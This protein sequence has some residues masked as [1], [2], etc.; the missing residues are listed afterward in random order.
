MTDVV[1]ADMLVNL[2][3]ICNDRPRVRKSGRRGVL[4]LV[5]GREWSSFETSVG[6]RI[7]GEGCRVE[8]LSEKERLLGD[9]ECARL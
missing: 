2:G 1:G 4:G 5:G 8:I 6:S 3:G 9:P 7:F